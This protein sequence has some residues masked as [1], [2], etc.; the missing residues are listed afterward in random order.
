MIMP[1]INLCAMCA[2]VLKTRVMIETS[3]AAILGLVPMQQG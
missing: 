1:I 3:L 2:A